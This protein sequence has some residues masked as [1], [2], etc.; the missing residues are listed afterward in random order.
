MPDRPDRSEADRIRTA[1][2]ML[3]SLQSTH[4]H[5]D[6]KAG[7]LAAAQ[8]ALV[9]TAGAWSGRAVDGWQRGGVPGL[10]AGV[11]LVLFAAGLLVGAGSL[12]LA[13]RPRLWEPAEANPYSYRRLSAGGP[14][15]LLPVGAEASRRELS[16][17]VRFLA[18]VAV[19]KYR[20]LATAVAGTAVMGV[21]AGLSVLLRPW[22]AG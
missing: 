5:A 1:E 14:D 10:V 3:G 11:L 18:G 12:A 13:L 19:A 6:S 20:W 21:S 2:F 16:Q 9:T 4:Q 8:A 17:A 15:V 22:L 7:I